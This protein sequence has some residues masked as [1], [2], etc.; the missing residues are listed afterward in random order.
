VSGCVSRFGPNISSFAY[1]ITGPDD[2]E[3]RALT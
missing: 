2:F 3:K 1:R